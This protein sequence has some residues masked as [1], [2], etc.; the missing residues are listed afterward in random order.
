MFVKIIVQALWF[1]LP[2]FFANMA[3]NIFTHVKFLQR[4]KKPIHLKAFG[5]HKT[6][7]GFLVGV[8]AALVVAFFQALVFL[9]CPQCSWLFLFPYSFSPVGAGPGAA[10]WFG[11]LQGFGSLLGDLLKSFFKR[12]L[13]IPSGA[14]FFPF[15]QLDAVIGG[16]LLGGIFYFPPLPHV[17]TLFFIT[18]P[19]QLFINFTA[20]KLG[21]KKVWW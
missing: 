15:D 10:L 9:S 11:F 18:P 4:F 16:L 2:A 20:Y 5:D 14:P 13:H 19:L 3:P 1:F 7:Y 8:P 17:L 12:R 21:L 6:Y